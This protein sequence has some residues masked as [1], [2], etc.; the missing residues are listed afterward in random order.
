VID[1]KSITTYMEFIIDM[2]YIKH[3]IKS[4]SSKVSIDTKF[5]TMCKRTTLLF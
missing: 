1:L 4:L 2:N 3:K 5:H